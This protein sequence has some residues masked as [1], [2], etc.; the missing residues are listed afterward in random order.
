MS[1]YKPSDAKLI[2][3]EA[4]QVYLDVWE[5]KTR[6]AESNCTWNEDIQHR[7]HE[8]IEKLASSVDLLSDLLMEAMQRIE[9]LEAQIAKK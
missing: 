9:A 3:S 2:S 5:T 7:N 4:H 6:F 8:A 1:N